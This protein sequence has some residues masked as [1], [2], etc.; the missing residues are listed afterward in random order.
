MSYLLG[1]TIEER[2]QINLRILNN[3][4]KI[5]LDAISNFH[6]PILVG[7]E[8]GIPQLLGT[9]MILEISSRYF[10]VTAGH[11]FDDV[12]TIY[13]SCEGKPLRL[14]GVAYTNRYVGSREDDK[15]DVGILEVTAER[16]RFEKEYRILSLSDIA[17]NENPEE[18]RY[19]GF[20]GYPSTECK[21]EHYSNNFKS[22]RYSYMSSVARQDLY[23][24]YGFDIKMHIGLHCDLYD[25]LDEKNEMATMPRPNGMSGGGVW[26]IDRWSYE[27]RDIVP[28]VK[29]VG[30]CIEYQEIDDFLVGIN[31]RAIAGLVRSCFLDLKSKL[32]DS[33]ILIEPLEFEFK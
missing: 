6:V 22:V 13:T 11:V 26:L 5:D 30:L 18:K 33:G 28:V 9:G 19:Y 8:N 2:L 25:C 3:R 12:S 14:S 31:I 1:T 24:K 27:L 7:D 32:P 16:D 20:I 10:L 17:F 4:R 15:V 21:P 29:L 23:D